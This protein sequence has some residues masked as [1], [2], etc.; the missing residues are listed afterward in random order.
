[1]TRP[2][3]YRASRKAWQLQRRQDRRV[4]H[5]LQWEFV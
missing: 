5:N 2:N 4:R 1:M 3:T